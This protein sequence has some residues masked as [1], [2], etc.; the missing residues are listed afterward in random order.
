[1]RRVP[2]IPDVPSGESAVV[3]D[4]SMASIWRRVCAALLGP[5]ERIVGRAIVIREVF[6]DAVMLVPFAA[7]N[8]GLDQ[9]FGWI[10]PHGFARTAC[11]ISQWG[12][13]IGSGITYVRYVMLDRP[14]FKR[15]REGAHRRARDRGVS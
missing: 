12:C 4:K 7:I 2:S 5:R 13:L 9:L 10:D 11:V 14:S 15:R 3:V 6:W 1:M 8:V